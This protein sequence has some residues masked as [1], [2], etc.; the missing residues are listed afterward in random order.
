MYQLGGA[1]R[2]RIGRALQL[3]AAR[4]NRDARSC[5]LSSSLTEALHLPVRSLYC[6]CSAAEAPIYCFSWMV[7]R[8]DTA[9]RRVYVL[10]ARSFAS[11]S[12]HQRCASGSPLTWCSAGTTRRASDRAIH[13]RFETCFSG[14]MGARAVKNKKVCFGRFRRTAERAD[15]SPWRRA[16]YYPLVCPR[17]LRGKEPKLSFAE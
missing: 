14:Q 4:C 6:C 9:S 7:V 17:V 12:W 15:A 10:R 8:L 5:P 11:L 3:A 13:P 1:H 2:G 16:F